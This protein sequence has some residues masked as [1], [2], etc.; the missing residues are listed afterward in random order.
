MLSREKMLT[1]FSQSIIPRPR[2]NNNK[3][4]AAFVGR[5]R[6][7]LS[8][9]LYSFAFTSPVSPSVL[10]VKPNRMEAD[11]YNRSKS[12]VLGK[13]NEKHQA[14]RS[15]ERSIAVAQFSHAPRQRLRKGTNIFIKLNLKVVRN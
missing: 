8:S 5:K 4:R 15:K 9:C 3:K 2:N 14:R 11:R 1:G 12:P 10:P 7:C 13:T 6:E